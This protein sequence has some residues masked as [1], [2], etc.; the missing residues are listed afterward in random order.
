[1][2]ERKI[3]P[4]SLKNLQNMNMEIQQLTREALETALIFLLETKEIGQITIAELVKK[5]GVSRNA[6]YRN[7][8]SK[9]ALLDSIFT[10]I[11]RRTFRRMYYFYK[12]NQIYQ[13]WLV[14]FR[15]AKK[16]AQVLRLAFKYNFDKQMSQ[17]LASLIDKVR[18]K[19]QQIESYTSSFWSSAIIA[20]ISK[21]VTDGMVVSEE[22]MAALGLPLLS[23]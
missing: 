4:Q 12:K 7:Y 3:S 21:W 16:E 20:I 8:Q 13:A 5:A 9:E 2:S 23:I 18:Q 6:F 14:L 19:Q 1:M 17:A 15:E 11:L 22:E 10:R